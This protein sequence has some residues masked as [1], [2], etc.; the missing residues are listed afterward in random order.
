MNVGV[1][2]IV[3]RRMARQPHGVAI[4]AVLEGGQRLRIEIRHVAFR[5]RGG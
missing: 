5:R 1:P 3:D 2:R 4:I